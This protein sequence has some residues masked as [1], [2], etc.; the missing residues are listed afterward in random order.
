MTMM[1]TIFAF[2]MA[3]AVADTPAPATT[4]GLMSYCRSLGELSEA[5]M[6]ARQNGVST[7]VLLDIIATEE[8]PGETSLATRIVVMAYKQP[9]F[10]T[11]EFQTEAVRDFRNEIETQCV[12]ELLTP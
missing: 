1:N 7:M 6:Q 4:E 5:I 12:Q 9:R 2:A 3:A 11:R 10:S 8:D